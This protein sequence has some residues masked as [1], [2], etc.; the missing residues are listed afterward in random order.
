MMKLG[1]ETGSLVNH[2]MSGDGNP[3]PVVGMGVTLL[4][5]TD[6]RP[7][8]VRKVVEIASKRWDYE[9]EVTEDDA[10]RIDNNGMS[11]SQEYE[12]SLREDGYRQ[13]FRRERATGAW[14]EGRISKNSGRFGRIG[15]RNCIV[16]GRR[17][18][19]HDFSF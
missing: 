5:W 13:L 8:T 9:I 2:L 12:Y 17:E 3:K 16:I 11:E 19:Y 14:C 7:G 10:K 18:K 15:G 4:S 6:R 1:T